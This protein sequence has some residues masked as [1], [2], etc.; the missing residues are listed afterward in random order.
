MKMLLINPPLFK[1]NIELIINNMKL[2]TGNATLV[3]GKNDPSYELG[4]LFK[5]E[6]YKNTFTETVFIDNADHNFKG[7][8]NEF[9]NLP[10]QY[11]YGKIS[12]LV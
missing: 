3:M 12:L 2:F 5:Q 1:E 11:L 7:L 6:I 10:F 9:V 8:I 4:K